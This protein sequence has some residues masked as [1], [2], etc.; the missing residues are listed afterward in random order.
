MEGHRQQQ[1]QQRL[2]GAFCNWRNF[3]LP[4]MRLESKT[5]E[6]SNVRRKYDDAWTPYQRLLEWG[7]ISQ[8]VREQLQ[9][10]Y[11]SLNP[12]VLHRRSNELLSELFALMFKQH[13]GGGTKTAHV[14]RNFFLLTQRVAA[15]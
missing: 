10:R 5:R 4:V 15:R 11:A 1:L 3:F 9:R 7:Q 6:G 12:I 2:Y 13:T 14:F 8:T